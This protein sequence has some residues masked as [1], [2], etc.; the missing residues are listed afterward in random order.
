MINMNELIKIEN[1]VSKTY[2]DIN[3]PFTE[4]AYVN[5]TPIAKRFNRKT[6]DYLKLAKTQEYIKALVQKLSVEGNP[7]TEETLIFIVQSGIPQNQ[8]T[9]LHPKLVI[10]FARW[11]NPE[12]ALWCD[13]QIENILKAKQ[14]EFK[15]PTTLIE[16]GK[17]WLAELEAHEETRKLLQDAKNLIEEAKPKIKYCDIVLA[18]PD[19]LTVTQIAQDYGISAQKLNKILNEEGVQYR[20][21]TGAWLLY[22][23][24]SAQGYAQTHTH[25]YRDST[26]V[27]HA[28]LHLKW[29]QKGR[30]FIYDLL[31]ARGIL[32]ICEQ[33]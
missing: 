9:W 21:N 3:I 1:Q 5:I 22:L 16:A 17:L 15:M 23:K 25:V 2:Q 24:Y 6:A 4:N 20:D 8:G 12:F 19:L 29:T 10:D 7:V 30:L 33:E 32:P 18:C 13:E 31:K 28:K 14:A 26:D 11:L 27:Q